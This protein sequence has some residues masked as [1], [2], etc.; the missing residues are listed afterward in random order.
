MTKNIITVFV[1]GFALVMLSGCETTS[2]AKHGSVS[3]S[4][5]VH[6]KCR[7][8][9]QDYRGGPDEIEMFKRCMEKH[10]YAPDGKPLNKPETTSTSSF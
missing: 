1:F 6:F 4:V 8:E 7:E 2:K 9:T 5:D 3:D 10:G